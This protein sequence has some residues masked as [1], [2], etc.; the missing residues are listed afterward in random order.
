M[1]IGQ[2]IKTFTTL[3]QID[4]PTGD[5]KEVAQKVAEL[6]SEYDLIP[7]IDKHFNVHASVPG[8]TGFEPIILNAHLDTVEPGRNIQIIHKDGIISS[9]GKTI[10]GIDD[11]IGVF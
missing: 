6:L 3:A 1:D 11:K 5:E 8:N 9:D 10:A 2:L 4:S 7:S